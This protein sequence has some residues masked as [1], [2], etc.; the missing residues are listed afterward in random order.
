M[1]AFHNL[2]NRNRS[3]MI[4]AIRRISMQPNAAGAE[5]ALKWRGFIGEFR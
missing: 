1:R 5:E 4:R 3:L 2:T